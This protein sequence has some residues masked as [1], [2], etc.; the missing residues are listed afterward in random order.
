MHF[1]NNL[2]SE[3]F[4]KNWKRRGDGVFFVLALEPHKS[5]VLHMHALLGAVTD[6]NN[7]ALR[8]H[9]KEWWYREFG[10][11]RIEQPKDAGDVQ[12][13]CTK[14][15]VKGGDINLSDTLERHAAFQPGL[16]LRRGRT[17]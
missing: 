8:V 6:L 15:V 3:L 9:W 4:G 14:Y 12:G 11:A 13:Y 17:K 10:I 2:N 5:N 7:M 16:D 1:I